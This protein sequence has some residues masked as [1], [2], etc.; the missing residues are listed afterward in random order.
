MID[1]EAFDKKHSEFPEFSLKSMLEISQKEFPKKYESLKKHLLNNNFGEAMYFADYIDDSFA[2]IFCDYEFRKT[3]QKVFTLAK[4]R[5]ETE[6]KK[7]FPVL[8][9]QAEEFAN[10]LM[11]FKLQA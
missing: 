9:K 10:N 4:E 1:R 6:L 2:F 7:I 11:E 8:E 3:L 5:N